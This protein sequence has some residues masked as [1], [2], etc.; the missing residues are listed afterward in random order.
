MDHSIHRSGNQMH[1]LQSHKHILQ[2]MHSELMDIRLHKCQTQIQVSIISFKAFAETH[3]LQLKTLQQSQSQHRAFSAS[4][5]I[6]HHEFLG[7]LGSKINSY[8]YALYVQIS[9]TPRACSV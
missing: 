9:V 6:M 7:A 3:I 4:N 1:S 5:D 2:C 8:C